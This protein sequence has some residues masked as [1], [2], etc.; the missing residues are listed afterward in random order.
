M[1]LNKK[2]EILSVKLKELIKKYGYW[3]QEVKDFNSTLDYN[4]MLIINDINKR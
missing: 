3:S 2:Q 1:K 4:T